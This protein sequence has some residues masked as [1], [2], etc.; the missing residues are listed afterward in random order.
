MKPKGKGAPNKTL[1]GTF[2]AGLRNAEHFLAIEE[3][4]LTRTLGAERA[5]VGE[6]VKT[7]RS[8]PSR[9]RKAT[10]FL[11]LLCLLCSAFVLSVV[12]EQQCKYAY[13]WRKYVC[14]N[15]Q[16]WP[17]VYYTGVW[18]TWHWNGQSHLEADYVDGEL[19]GYVKCW[20]IGGRVLFVRRF[21]NGNWVFSGY[22]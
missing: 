8:V 22:E 2:P 20:D 1:N 17:P 4:P 21:E 6:S 7:R 16:D 10:S 12:D 3:S 19:H 14:H 5:S 9:A 18:R 15:A 11:L 13:I